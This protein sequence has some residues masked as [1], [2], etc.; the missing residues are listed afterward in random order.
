MNTVKLFAAAV[1]FGRAAFRGA[2]LLVTLSIPSPTQPFIGK[3]VVPPDSFERDDILQAETDVL[4]P[5]FDSM[6]PVP[7]YVKNEP[8]LK[9]G[10]NTERGA[11]YTHCYAG[12]SPSI[13][14][15][16]VF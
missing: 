2:L 16:K 14:V 15:K 7:V 1:H 5:L 13:F 4:L 12:E 10:T 3:V 9:S 6:P 8:I 11:A